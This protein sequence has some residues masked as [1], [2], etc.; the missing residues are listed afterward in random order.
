MKETVYHIEAAW[1]LPGIMSALL[2]TA[3]SLSAQVPFR[4]AAGDMMLVESAGAVRVAEKVRAGAA[5][6]MVEVF[7]KPGDTVTKGQVLGH[8]ELDATKLQFDLAERALNARANVESARSQAEA[9]TVTREET[10]EAVRRRKADKTRL[11]WAAAMEKMY[12]AKYESELDNESLQS[13]QY[14]YWKSQYEKRF[15]RSPVDGV[16]TEVLTEVGRPVP[17]ASHVFT[18]SNENVYSIPV[19]VPAP[20]AEAA[21]PSDTVPVRAADGKSVTRAL[22]DSVMD[23]PRGAGRKIIRL[24]VKSADFPAAIRPRLKGM[25]FDVLLPELADAKGAAATGG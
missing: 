9:W 25:K 15:F 10:E 19:N 3:F 7:V 8:T 11:D 6:V 5:G 24:L 4:S 14:E 17:L 13:I 16:V 20:L 12:L 21:Q 1:R 2:L 22:V 18:V 23:D